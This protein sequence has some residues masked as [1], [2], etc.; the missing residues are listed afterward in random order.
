MMNALSLHVRWHLV[1]PHGFFLQAGAFIVSTVKIRMMNTN[2]HSY[3]EKT[4][5]L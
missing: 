2:S 1:S 4:V 5:T 3:I